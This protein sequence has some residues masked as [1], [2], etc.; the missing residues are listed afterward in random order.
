V[1]QIVQVKVLGVDVALQRISLTMKG[2]QSTPTPLQE[3]RQ[4]PARP[5]R[6]KRKKSPVAQEKV[7][8][9]IQPEPNMAEK[10]RALQAHF[11]GG[12]R[13]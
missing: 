5:A 11:R 13:S 10:L 9:V 12:G 4:R 7:A 6:R 2:V 3:A 8:P 1:G